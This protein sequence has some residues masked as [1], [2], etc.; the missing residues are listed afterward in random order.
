[1]KILQI[2]KFTISI[3]IAACNNPKVDTVI[4]E[5]KM[6]VDST[7]ID[8]AL[9]I[10]ND[11][12]NIFNDTIN[13]FIVDDYQIT[14]SMLLRVADK[15]P[16]FII[17]AGQCVSLE[18]AWFFNDTI[19]QVIIIQLA[20]DYHRF[21]TFHFT[22]SNFPAD[23][24]SEIGLE[25]NK[26]EPASLKQKLIDLNGLVEQATII[27]SSYFIS[28]RSFKLGDT[29]QKAISIY[30]KPDYELKD[31]QIEKL[32]WQFEGDE[33]YDGKSNLNGRPLAKGSFGHNIKMYFKNDRLIGQ[34]LFNDIP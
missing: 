10:E 15:N 26:G 34:I 2:L 1:M 23:L 8:T 16:F 4:N 7:S 24:V 21:L 22:K 31:G 3:G 32:E 25:N 20:T 5:N 19:D 11:V 28:H 6:I 29:K 27:N 17:K 13:T 18:K 14:D 30:G 33:L 12:S 9:I